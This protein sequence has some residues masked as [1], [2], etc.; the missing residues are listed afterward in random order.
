MIV[1]NDNQFLSIGQVQER[2]L[3][4]SDKS[5][6]VNN[7]PIGNNSFGAILDRLQNQT[8]EVKFSKHA[9]NR[10]S[11]RN[12]ELTAEQK[13]RL[14]NGMKQASEK[15]INDSLIMVDQLAFIVNVPNNT[16][17][18]AL[19]STEKSSNVF[20]NIDGAVIA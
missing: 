5:S 14:S 4:G 19:D 2:Y 11:D 6:K 12:I 16:V 10:L 7:I 8:E 13:E 18:T 1:N 17:V 15:G 9:A 3:N 20:T